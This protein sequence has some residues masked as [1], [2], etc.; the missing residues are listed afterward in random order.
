MK[1]DWKFE[2]A[3]FMW[4]AARGNILIMENIWKRN[5]CFVE[6]CCM[7]KNSGQTTDHLLLCGYAHDLWSLVLS[8]WSPLCYITKRV[9]Q[10]L[11]CWSF[12]K[13]HSADIWLPFHSVLCGPFGERN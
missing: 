2:I 12:G 1:S 3:F 13:H 5:F 8:F 7:C 11:A 6:W 4:I 9:V 10:L